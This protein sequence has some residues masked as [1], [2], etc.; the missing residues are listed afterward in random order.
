MKAARRCV[1]R[2]RVTWW[3]VAVSFAGGCATNGVSRSPRECTASSQAVDAYVGR[4]AG[5]ASNQARDDVLE[6]YESVSVS[7]ALSADGSASEF[8]LARP[9]R[10]AAGEEVLRAATAAAPYPR[11]PFD[12]QA[13]LVGGRATIGVIGPRRCDN[14]RA[15]EYTD[16]V[17]SRIQRAVGDAGIAAPETQD[18][19]LRV[20]VG[21]KGESASIQVHDARSAEMGERVAAVARKLAFEAP[22]DSITQCV[23]DHPFFVWIRLTGDTRPPVRIR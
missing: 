16:T 5:L 11:P 12:P 18:V 17:A 7:F 22:G 19:A 15:S 1:I 6:P 2:I 9:S 20:K 14:T 3:L 13:C 4:I 8:R 10:P 21:R 23:A